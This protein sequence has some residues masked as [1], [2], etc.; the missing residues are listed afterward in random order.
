MPYQKHSDFSHDEEPR[1]GILLTNLGTPEAPTAA[2]LRP[3]LKQFLSD[4]RVV[5]FPR[6]LWWLVLNLIILRIRPRR[7]AKAYQKVWSEKGSPLLIHTQAQTE[8]VR[9]NLHAKYGKKIRVEFAMRYGNP[10]IAAGIDK[11]M[12]AGV[13][14]LLVLPLYPQYSATT[15]G[16]TFDAIADNFKRRRWLPELHFIDGYHT[17]PLYINALATSIQEHW[18]KHGRPDKLIFSYHGVPLRYLHNGDPYHCYCL[19]TTRLVAEKLALSEDDYLSSFQSR[20]GRE[21]WLQPYTDE[22]L[23]HLAAQGVKSVAVVCPGFSSDCLETLEEIDEENREYFLSAGGKEFHYIP[24][25]N[26]APAH[27]NALATI[28]EDNV[29]RWLTQLSTEPGQTRQDRYTNYST[30]KPRAPRT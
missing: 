24:A 16:S 12:R 18:Q 19:Q 3:Y 30:H 20:F 25:L 15:T 6:L 22:T 23:K 13:R 21:A 4:P 10:S 8:S 7:S 11:L 17:H 26:N 9:Q 14:K 1:V 29:A 28:C 5:E 2:A 27:I